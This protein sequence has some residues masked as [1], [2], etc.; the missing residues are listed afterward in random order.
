MG[1]E[2]LGGGFI[3]ALVA[4]IVA[5]LALPKIRA[6]ARKLNADAS[7]TEWQTLKDEID[8]LNSTVRMQDKRIAE[9][10]ESAKLRAD[11]ATELERENKLLRREV[12]RLRL[13]VEGLESILRAGPVTDDMKALLAELDR[14]TKN[15]SK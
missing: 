15:G 9:L 13:R 10:E 11:R 8:R 12:G 3:G 5:L 6:E 4:L 2:W 14:K 7:R 1:A